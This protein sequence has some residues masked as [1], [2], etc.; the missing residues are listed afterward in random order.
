MRM[1]ISRRNIMK[2]GAALAVLAVGNK[3][4]AISS[5]ANPRAIEALIKNSRL[6]PIG[7]GFADVLPDHIPAP[8]YKA[9][10]LEVEDPKTGEITTYVHEALYR[11]FRDKFG[12]PADEG[13]DLGI[14]MYRC[15]WRKLRGRWRCI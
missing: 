11:A 6:V 10:Y 12:R 2:A 8:I 9:I 4:D 7:N 3:A 1:E 5:N 15:R 14:V 13:D